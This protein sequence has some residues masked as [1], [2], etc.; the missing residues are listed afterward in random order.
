MSLEI[1]TLDS[2]FCDKSVNIVQ[3]SLC[4]LALLLHFHLSKGLIRAS[5]DLHG[6]GLTTR[7]H[8]SIAQVQ[9]LDLTNLDLDELRVKNS[10]Q[11]S[12]SILLPEM[13]RELSMM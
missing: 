5:D 4:S 8:Q 1:F 3:C 11:I 10:L 2:I 7:N 6:G 13:Y 12:V 9:L